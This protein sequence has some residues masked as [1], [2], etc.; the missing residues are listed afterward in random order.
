MRDDSCVKGCRFDS[1]HCLLDGLTFFTFIC[2]KKLYRLF[3]K[4]EI[5]DKE[6]GVGPFLEKMIILIEIV[7]QKQILERPFI[8]II[9]IVYHNH[10]ELNLQNSFSWENESYR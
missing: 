9:T 5:N 7:K 1:R 8:L 10:R 3:E 6:A 2:C 4:T